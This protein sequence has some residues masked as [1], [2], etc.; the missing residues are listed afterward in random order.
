MSFN[1][2]LITSRFLKYKQCKSRIIKYN[3]STN[4][5]FL[6]IVSNNEAIVVDNP[7]KYHT[8]VI[9]N[10]E[11]GKNAMN[12]DFFNSIGNIFEQFK[13]DGVQQ[14]VVSLSNSGNVFSSGLDLMD[15]GIRF[16]SLKSKVDSKEKDTS[17]ISLELLALLKNMQNSFKKVRECP[18][19]VICSINGPCI[20]SG[21]ELAASTDIRL[22][23]VDSWFQ[24]KEIDIAIAA[25]LGALHVGT[26]I[27]SNDSCFREAC[28]TGR[29]F[30]AHEAEQMGL[31][32]K[33]FASKSEMDKYSNQ[34]VQEITLKSPI[35]LRGTKK[36]LNDGR[37]KST[38]DGLD[39]IALWNMAMLQ[40]QDIFEAMQ[41]ILSKK[42]PEFKDL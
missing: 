24:V 37:E 4:D 40:S 19:P 17:R 3:S 8:K 21:F 32:S 33:V 1:C 27:V 42:K 20:G 16:Q 22:A 41:S 36:A 12:M 25:D 31:I 28:F 7:N 10:N 26:K 18:V 2:S 13:C 39:E 11:A 34:L 35:A 30:N 9:L 15:F 29:K 23:T 14:R 6:K 38:N 5:S